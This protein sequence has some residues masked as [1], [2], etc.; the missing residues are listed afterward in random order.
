MRDE[1]IVYGCTNKKHQGMFMG[2]ICA[3]C[4]GIITT[5]KAN[6]TD[7]FLKI[8]LEKEKETLKFKESVIR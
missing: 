7:S 3:P 1:C 2:D 6:Q 4:W 8:L 5:G